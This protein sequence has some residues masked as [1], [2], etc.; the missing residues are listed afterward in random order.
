MINDRTHDMQ[1]ENDS[2]IFCLAITEVKVAYTAAGPSDL[3]CKRRVEVWV[4]ELASRG[5]KAV[6]IYD[7]VESVELI[8]CSVAL[9]RQ[10]NQTEVAELLKVT[11]KFV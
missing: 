4:S 8:D 5:V 11:V 10:I 6:D 2:E 9:F 3:C 7:A 1:R